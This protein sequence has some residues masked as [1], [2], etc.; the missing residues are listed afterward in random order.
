VSQKL[1]G[2][3]SISTTIKHYAGVMPEALREAQIRL[4]FGSVLSDVSKSDRRPKSREGG[5][6][7]RIITLPRTTG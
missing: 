6:R 5:Y 2:H 4:P 1:A 7:E 3:A